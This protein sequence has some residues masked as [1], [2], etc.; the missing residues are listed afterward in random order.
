MAVEEARRAL[1]AHDHVVEH[2]RVVDQAVDQQERRLARLIRLQH[3]DVGLAQHLFRHGEAREG[4]RAALLLESTRHGDGPVRGRMEGQGGGGVE[5]HARRA[6]RVVELQGVGRRAARGGQPGVEVRAQDGRGVEHRGG[7]EEVVLPRPPRVVAL[8]RHRG[9]EARRLV[10][11]VRRGVARRG[12]RVHDPGEILVRPHEAGAPDRHR[13]R[14]G[15]AVHQQRRPRV[16]PTEPL[17]GAEAVQQARVVQVAGLREPLRLDGPGRG[18]RHR[19]RRVRRCV[20][21]QHPQK[22]RHKRQARH[23]W[24]PRVRPRY[25]TAS[26]WPA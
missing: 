25:A 24:E 9:A 18:P 8:D 1:Q 21:H 16:E 2:E 26:A 13:D 7:R 23:C 12:G 3:P 4:E 6:Q 20:G 19:R 15:R 14:P 11:G 10:V 17:P 5:G 22:Q